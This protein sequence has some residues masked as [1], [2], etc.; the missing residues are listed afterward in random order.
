[1]A[2][3]MLLPFTVQQC[4]MH[5]RGT[6]ARNLNYVVEKIT[7]AFSISVELLDFHCPHGP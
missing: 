6:Q 4:Q 7:P 3:N 2:P 5:L 1:M